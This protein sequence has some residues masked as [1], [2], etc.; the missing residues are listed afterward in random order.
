MEL[1]EAL[2]LVLIFLF[3]LLIYCLVLAALN[4][5]PHPVVVSGPWDF[6]GVVLALSGFLVAGGPAI[7]SNLTTGWDV[8]RRVTDEPAALSPRQVLLGA[9]LVLYFALLVVGIVLGLRRRRDVTS[10]YNVDPAAFDEVL[11]EVLDDL[12]YSW[13]RGGNRFYL[14]VRAAPPEKEETAVIEAE[15][16][17]LMYHVS[18]RWGRLGPGMRQELEG[19]MARSLAGVPTRANPVGNWFL[20]V[21]ITLFLLMAGVLLFLLV[22][23]LLTRL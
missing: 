12:G 8:L 23:N 13:A 4:R 21:G 2:V 16:F 17:P 20:S 22:A 3:P 5:R 18:V 15:P 7:L 11:G 10:V 1:K 14:T 9:L 6:L 19:E